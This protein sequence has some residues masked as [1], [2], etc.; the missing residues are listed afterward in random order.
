MKGLL[1]RKIGMTRVIDPET[2][3]M[4]TVTVLQA[5]KA[6]ILQV[7]TSQNDGYDA[8]VLG[9][10]ERKNF[11]KN[12]NKK[13][14]FIKELSVEN[15]AFKKGDE[16]GVEQ[17]ESV[18]KVGIKG[19]SQGKGFAGVIK[20]HNFSRGPETHGSHHHREPGSS[21]MCAKPARILKGKKMPGRMGNDSITLR[22]VKVVKVDIAQNLIA[23]KGPVPGPKNSYCFI[24]A[25]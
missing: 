5:P 16:V 9:A 2:G 6:K 25:N 4:T 11:G 14:K 24:T 1:A 23:L 20:R 10:F 19:T 8:L 3:E 12:E 15:T 22:D 13:Y 7:K 18:E 17:F 21:G